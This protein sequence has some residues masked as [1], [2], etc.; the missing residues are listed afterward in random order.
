MGKGNIARLNYLDVAKGIAIILVVLGHAN[1]G[2][3]YLCNWI[4]SFHMP[5]FFIVSGILLSFK[6]NWKD[7]D[8]NGIV[9]K[10][11]KQL[12]YPYFTFSLLMIL[13]HIVVALKNGTYSELRNRIL[14]TICLYGADTFWFL[15]TLFIAEVIFIAIYKYAKKKWIYFLIIFI[16]STLG[17]YALQLE[18]W[19]GSRILTV[20][21]GFFNVIIR[22]SI[23]AIFIEVGYLFYK[24]RDFIDKYSKYAVILSVILFIANIYICQLN[25]MVDL[26]YSKINNFILYY[27]CSVITSLSILIILQY[28][29][30]SNKLLEYYGRNSLIIMSTHLPLPLL[31]YSARLVRHMDLSF[32]TVFNSILITIIVMILE[33]ICIEIINRKCKFLIKMK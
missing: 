4:S 27:E 1:F 6:D 30:K 2:D 26:H 24:M 25:H 8:M 13:Y 7:Q 23:A 11:A 17:A 31:E 9:I 12:L 10:K 3:N 21:N 29:I 22:S 20:L 15:S 28:V 16:V 19:N 32:G 33:V 14:Q 5:I 18:F